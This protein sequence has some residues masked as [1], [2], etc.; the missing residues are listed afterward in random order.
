MHMTCKYIYKHTRTYLLL[1]SVGLPDQTSSET[2]EFSNWISGLHTY[3]FYRD[4]GVRMPAVWICVWSRP[5]DGFRH[6]RAARLLASAP[7]TRC[8]IQGFTEKRQDAGIKTV[9]WE[10]GLVKVKQKRWPCVLSKNGDSTPAVNCLLPSCLRSGSPRADTEQWFVSVW[11]DVFI[12]EEPW[13][14]RGGGRS[15]VE[16]GACCSQGWAESQAQPDPQ[17]ALST[18]LLLG[19]GAGMSHF[20]TA[21]QGHCHTG[22]EPQGACTL[23]MLSP[24]DHP[25][26]KLWVQLSEARPRKGH[27]NRSEGSG[28]LGGHGH[29]ASVLN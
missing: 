12:R 6:S 16:A 26:R 17:G 18:N 7:S 27:W 28:D 21:R 22:S 9:L 19:K 14:L 20:R 4:P 1:L 5:A 3:W 29:W 11:R 23:G 24:A 8:C 2:L 25:G 10:V 15:R 13:E